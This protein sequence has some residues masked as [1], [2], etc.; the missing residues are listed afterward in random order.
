MIDSSEDFTTRC[1]L[2]SDRCTVPE[3]PAPPMSMPSHRTHSAVRS[4]VDISA[5]ARGERAA[6]AAVEAEPADTEFSCDL[7]FEKE[8]KIEPE[9]EE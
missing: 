8:K 5:Y 4:S 7:R 3:P 1:T 9:L 6:D 2:I